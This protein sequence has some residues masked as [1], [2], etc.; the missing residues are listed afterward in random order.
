MKLILRTQ[1]DVTSTGRI[2]EGVERRA[3]FLLDY[4]GAGISH[5]N[6]RFEIHH[7][8][9]GTS[10]RF[11]NPNL[12]REMTTKTH[13]PAIDQNRG[14]ANR[15]KTTYPLRSSFLRGVRVRRTKRNLDF[16]VQRHS[17]TVLRVFHHLVAPLKLVV[18]DPFHFA[19]PRHELL[20]SVLPVN[21]NTIHGERRR[22]D[23]RS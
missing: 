4:D 22:V 14:C 2:K 9:V 17:W 12:F 19:I 11:A 13:Y 5:S 21:E 10:E 23:R 20:H 1:F 15:G 16:F 3:C 18:F 7:P 8:L 6:V